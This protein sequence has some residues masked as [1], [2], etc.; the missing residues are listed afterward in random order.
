MLEILNHLSPLTHCST[1]KYIYW[2]YYI[3]LLLLLLSCV[4]RIKVLVSKGK[5]PVVKI[6]EII[7]VSI[8]R[9]VH[10]MFTHITLSQKNVARKKKCIKCAITLH[11]GPLMDVP[12]ICVMARSKSPIRRQMT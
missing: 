1:S 10:Q 6:M 3:A 2:C 12:A 9:N 5:F 8:Y 4:S 11:A 7:K